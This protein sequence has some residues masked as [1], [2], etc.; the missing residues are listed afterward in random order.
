MRILIPIIACLVLVG[1]EEKLDTRIIHQTDP[2]CPDSTRMLFTEL[3]FDSAVG[4]ISIPRSELKRAIIR[5]R[6]NDY[7]LI[8][9]GEHMSAYVRES[10][11]DF[12]QPLPCPPCDEVI[13]LRTRMPPGRWVVVDSIGYVRMTG[14]HTYGK[15][16]FYYIGLRPDSV[17]IPRKE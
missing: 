16:Q 8:W 7:Q 10:P 13:K 5:T 12:M 11:F 4:Y 1:C 15:Y 2:A 3:M 9:V 6:E 17:F 14:W